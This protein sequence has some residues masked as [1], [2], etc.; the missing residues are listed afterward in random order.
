[1]IGRGESMIKSSRLASNLF[2]FAG[3]DGNGVLD[4]G[5]FGILTLLK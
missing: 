5:W 1:M 4:I 2:C 3:N